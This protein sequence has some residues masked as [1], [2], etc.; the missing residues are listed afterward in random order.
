[1]ATMFGWLRLAALWASRRKRS[2]KLG[3]R[4]Y[5]AKR[6]F[7]ATGRS[8][9][10]SRARYTSA[11]PPRAMPRWISYRFEKTSASCVI[12]TKPYLWAPVRSWRSLPQDLAHHLRRD[13]RRDAPARRLAARAPAMLDEDGHD[14]LR[15]VGGREPYEPR[16]RAAGLVLGGACLARHRDARDPG[17]LPCAALD[18][19]DHERRLG[20]SGLRRH[21]SAPRLGV[22]GLH[23]VVVGVGD[24]VG[25]VGLHDHAVVR[26][27]RRSQRHLQRGHGDVPLTDA[28]ER[29]QGLV[30]L[31]RPGRGAHAVGRAGRDVQ[32]RRR[33]DP[34]LLH[35]RHERVAEVE[36]DLPERRVARDGEAVGQG[37]AA[38]LTAEVLQRVR[39]LGQ[40]ELGQLREVRLGCELARAERH[41]GGDDLERRSRGEALAVRARQFGLVGVGAQERLVVLGDLGVVAR[42]RLRGVAGVG[43]HG[44]DRTRLRVHHDD[45]SLLAAEGILRRI[46]EL[47]AGRQH[48]VADGL[49]PREHIGDIPDLEQGIA[50]RELV[51]VGALDAHVP[52]HERLV[53]RELGEQFALRVE[54]LELEFVAGLYRPG[55]DLAVSCLDLAAWL[56]EVAQL[57]PDVARVVGELVGVVDLEVRQLSDEQQDQD[58]D[59][60][61]NPPD[62]AIH[63][64]ASTPARAV[65]LAARSADSSEMRRSNAMTTKLAISEEPPY[66]TNGSVTPVRGMSRVTPPRMTNVWMPMMLVRPAAN[67]FGNGRSACTAIRNPAATSSRNAIRIAT[68][69][70]SPSSSPIA[71]KMK[72]V[73]A[74]GILSGLPSPRPVPAKPPDPN[75]NSDWT[76]W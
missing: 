64:R 26:D 16:V 21:R 51:V 22:D 15:V 37:A 61:P 33:P 54:P 4:A 75:E 27:R 29:E 17:G 74:F 2:T 7:T 45:R 44:Q 39:R 49:L 73:D 69:P 19:G 50:T 47:P 35:P 76:I 6:T 20:Q 57:E 62:R 8:S 28:R 65:G 13:R 55:D 58:R 53:A 67:S 3:S 46:L 11:I 12:G 56:G 71:E 63:R 31:E 14:D 48:D 32:R 34:E 43:V 18:D 10:R 52:E 36:P 25:D 60:D 41:G 30:L 66:E 38:P 42:E 70:S 68:V 23:R 9:R 24:P 59:P 1:M 72:S 40:L 5:S